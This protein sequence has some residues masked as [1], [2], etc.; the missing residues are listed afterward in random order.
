MMK[1]TYYLSS[2]DTCKR[3]LNAWPLS[4]DH[5]LQDVKND[6]LTSDQLEALFEMSGSYKD[7]INGRARLFKEKGLTAK[8]ID[9]D[10]AKALLLEHYTFL[11]RPVTILGDQLFIGNGKKE[12]AAVAEALAQ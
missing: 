9:E 6:P 12:V 2:C 5:I 4:D 3:I 11:K 10:Q 8:T 1:K 7:L